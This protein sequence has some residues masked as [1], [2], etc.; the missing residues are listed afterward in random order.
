MNRVNSQ[1]G[2]S[3]LKQCPIQPSHLRWYSVTSRNWPPFYARILCMHPFSCIEHFIFRCYNQARRPCPNHLKMN[4][5]VRGRLRRFHS[6]GHTVLAI[7][8]DRAR[9]V[10]VP[11]RFVASRPLSNLGTCPALLPSVNVYEWHGFK[12]E[13]ER[14]LSRV[15]WPWAL[16]QKEA[17]PR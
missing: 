17:S 3:V 4:R 7:G 13:C 5:Y 15:S 2:Y 8:C 12:F 1:G 11:E 9:L 16:C 6:A 14:E 10:R